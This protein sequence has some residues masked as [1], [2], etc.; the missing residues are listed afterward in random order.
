MEDQIPIRPDRS[1]LLGRETSKWS[2][3]KI[4]LVNVVVAV[5]FNFNDLYLVDEAPCWLDCPPMR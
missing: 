3:I 4:T 2:F 1:L 5:R